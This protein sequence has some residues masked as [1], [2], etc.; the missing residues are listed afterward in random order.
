MQPGDKVSI[1]AL[2]PANVNKQLEGLRLSLEVLDCL[3]SFQT[4]MLP[5][6]PNE[7]ILDILELT[8]NASKSAALNICLLS[9]NIGRMIRP[10]L[11]RKVVLLNERQVMAFAW[12]LRNTFIFSY[13]RTLW[14]LNTYGKITFYMGMELVPTK[15]ENLEDLASSTKWM[16]DRPYQIQGHGNAGFTHLKRLCLFG[17]G[18]QPIPRIISTPI[19]HLHLLEPTAR[20]MN[21]MLSNITPSFHGLKVL[22]L[23]SLTPTRALGFSPN[24]VSRFLRVLPNITSLTIKL[25]MSYC[26]PAEVQR[27]AIGFR[28]LAANDSR[29]SLSLNTIREGLCSGDLASYDEARRVLHAVNETSNEW[30]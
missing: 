21:T 9:R 6:L 13:T 29:L 18:T 28:A 27:I 12:T 26:L 22:C 2:A 20:G 16:M 14:V 23:E 17:I 10:I 19:T 1:T 8:A 24:H 7:I 5:L 11:Y 25:D 15:C 30:A 4:I 3:H